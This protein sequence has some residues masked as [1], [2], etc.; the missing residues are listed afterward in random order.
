MRRAVTIS[1]LALLVALTP[2][3]RPVA[4]SEA[5]SSFE[6]PSAVSMLRESR[7]D[8]AKLILVGAALIALAAAVRRIA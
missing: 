6:P 2:A 7:S 8:G 5:E 1:V 4:S 3:S